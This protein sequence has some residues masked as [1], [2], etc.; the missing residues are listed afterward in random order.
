[1]AAAL[2]KS[3]QYQQAEDLYRKVLRSDPNNVDALIGLGEVYLSLAESREDDGDFLEEAE[4][5]F[6]QALK[7]GKDS[8][9]SRQLKPKCFPDP[10]SKTEAPKYKFVDLAD[11]YYALGYVKVKQYEKKLNRFDKANLSSAK[12]YFDKAHLYNRDNFKALR[13][14]SKISKTLQDDGA[15]TL[16]DKI[17]SRA[18][19]AIA[20]VVFVLCQLQFFYFDRPSDNIYY[21]INDG[22]I[23]LFTQL[24]PLD[25]ATQ[26]AIEEIKNVRFTDSA[27]LVDSLKPLLGEELY[28]NHLN[29]LNSIDFSAKEPAVSQAKISTGY[30]ALISFGA[31]VFVIAGLFLPQLMKLKVGPIELEKNILVETMSTTSIGIYR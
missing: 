12:T 23:A 22:N 30:Y 4:H 28:A 27:T 15:I 3:Q 24:M 1:M 31:L 9:G 7:K 18:L 6:L 25:E 16:A 2:Y 20:A 29:L 10:M 13:A 21:R 19:A 11:L 26:K 5:H 14:S 8:N 17:A